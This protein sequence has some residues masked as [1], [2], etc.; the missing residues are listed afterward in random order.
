MTECVLIKGIFSFSLSLGRQGVKSVQVN[1]KK[2]NAWQLCSGNF[3]VWPLVTVF[4]QDVIPCVLS[5]GPPSPGSLLQDV[6]QFGHWLLS[7]VRTSFLVYS[8]QVYLHHVAYFTRFYSMTIGYCLQ[9]GR[10]SLCT[11]YRS[12]FT[13]TY[14]RKLHS[15]TI[16]YCLHSER[17]SLCTQYRSTFNRE[18]TSESS[19]IWPL[20]TVFSQG[21]IPWVLW[22]YLCQGQGSWW[23]Q[24][25]RA[26]VSRDSVRSSRFQSSGECR[27]PASLLA[28]GTLVRICWNTLLSI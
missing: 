18:L 21:I 1:V 27:Q 19:T 22:T 10:H 17:H 8:V 12:T 2:D 3:T 20:V 24:N 28:A 13:S 6:L 25:C 26:V 16:G 23:P 15:M 4:S 7:S 5:T 9:S 14:F 11:Q